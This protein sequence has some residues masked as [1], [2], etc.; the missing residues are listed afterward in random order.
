MRI[1]FLFTHNN[2]G[3]AWLW[4]LSFPIL[5]LLIAIG[6]PEP[7]A[8]T[9]EKVYHV[10]EPGVVAPG[11]KHSVQPAYT[12]EDQTARIMGTVVLSFEID[13]EGRT[14]QVK[15]VEGLDPGLD[16]N[17]VAAVSTW[18]F[19]P[20]TKDGQPVVCAARTQVAFRLR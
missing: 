10:G 11:L 9:D 18:L 2:P 13:K 8:Q 20:A 15:I 14:Q 1:M 19:D 3:V 17:A 16:K 4:R 5:L 7:R 12:D 6:F